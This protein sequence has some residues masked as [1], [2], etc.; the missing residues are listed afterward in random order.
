MSNLVET[1]RKLDEA[2]ACVEAL[3]WRLQPGITFDDQNKWCCPL[4]AVWICEGQP[5]VPRVA[6]WAARKLDITARE[7]G[8]FMAGFDGGRSKRRFALLGRKYRQ[9]ITLGVQG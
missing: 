8:W 2:V 1:E 6:T 3:G 9:R 4:S 7:A 5:I